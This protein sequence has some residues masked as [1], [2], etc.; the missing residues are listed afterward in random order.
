MLIAMGSA[1]CSACLQQV[2]TYANL[3]SWVTTD[4]NVLDACRAGVGMVMEVE[5][6]S[7]LHKQVPRYKS[8]VQNPLH[9][10]TLGCFVHW[11]IQ[12]E[13][14]QS[15]ARRI[16]VQSIVQCLQ[17]LLVFWSINQLLAC[18]AASGTFQ[19][20]A[21]ITMPALTTSV[22]TIQTCKLRSADS[23]RSPR[24]SLQLLQSED[25]PTL[26]RRFAQSVHWCEF[27]P[28][29]CLPAEIFALRLSS[30]ARD[31]LTLPIAGLI[32]I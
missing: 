7:P 6:L 18:H 13:Q 30:C 2:Q 14:P 23:L 9:R 31:A 1:F 10:C 29:C 15:W 11:K 8:E 28:S 26:H 24:L 17:T 16:W 32:Q 19:S 12:M 22:H 20:K 4:M 27:L 21:L 25:H 5:A 3:K